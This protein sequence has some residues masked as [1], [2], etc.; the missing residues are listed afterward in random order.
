MPA[1]G[2][3]AVNQLAVERDFKA[4]ALR[5]DQR[6]GRELALELL[7]EVGDETRRPGGVVSNDAE[8]D[9]QLHSGTSQGKVTAA[10]STR[11]SASAPGP[12]AGTRAALAGSYIPTRI[13]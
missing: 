7:E 4:A 9:S 5:R 11:S 13:S 10:I 12:L 6:D 8:F 3:L 2:E 1:G